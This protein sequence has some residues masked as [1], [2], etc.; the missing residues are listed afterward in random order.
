MAKAKTS[1]NKNSGTLLTERRHPVFCHGKVRIKVLEHF[2]LGMGRRLTSWRKLTQ[3]PF[4]EN[5]KK[6]ELKQPTILRLL[7]HR[8]SENVIRVEVSF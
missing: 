2:A 4:P 8:Y 7:Y 6:T 5:T 3:Q 1:N